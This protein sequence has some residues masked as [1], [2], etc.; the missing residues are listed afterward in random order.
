MRHAKTDPLKPTPSLLVALGS[1]AV[2]ADEY[3]SPKGHPFDADAIRSALSLP[4]VKAWIA[5]MDAIGLLPRKRD[6]A[7]A[8]SAT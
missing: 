2:H 6:L 8:E 4:E 5:E 3:L 1:I 7:T